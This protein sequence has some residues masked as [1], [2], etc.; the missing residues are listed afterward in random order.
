M[1]IGEVGGP[2]AGV[3]IEDLGAPAGVDQY[4]YAGLA[5]EQKIQ[6]HQRSQMMMQVC[7]FDGQNM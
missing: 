6:L 4:L 2:W 7:V 1:C 3:R 5:P